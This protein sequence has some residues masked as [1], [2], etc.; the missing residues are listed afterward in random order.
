[1]LFPLDLHEGHWK[2]TA[3]REKFQNKDVFLMH[4]SFFTNYTILHLHFASICNTVDKKKYC[5]MKY[6]VEIQSAQRRRESQTNFMILYQL[7]GV[8]INQKYNY[9]FIRSKT[10]IV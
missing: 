2:K 4:D 3:K 9:Y 1:M 5:F 7:Q 6:L 8:V 10:A